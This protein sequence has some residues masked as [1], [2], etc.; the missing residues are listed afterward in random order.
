MTT[1]PERN[2]RFWPPET[3]VLW[4]LSS[5]L[6][7]GDG[8]PLDI[9]SLV[10]DT[11]AVAVA[12]KRALRMEEK[13]L[14]EQ[15]AD[16]HAVNED[17]VWRSRKLLQDLLGS[18]SRWKV[19]PNP[20][21]DCISGLVHASDTISGL[22]GS[23]LKDLA[24]A[25]M[26]RHVGV[27]AAPRATGVGP[28]R[29]SPCR[30]GLCVCGSASYPRAAAE[31]LSKFL[32]RQSVEDLTHLVLHWQSTHWKHDDPDMQNW[33]MANPSIA[34]DDEQQN[35]LVAMGFRKEDEDLWAQ[36]AWC[37]LRPFRATL[38]EVTPSL[39]QNASA[40]GIIVQEVLDA[41]GLPKLY[42][43]YTWFGDRMHPGMCYSLAAYRFSDREAP[44]GQ[45]HGQAY[46]A[47]PPLEELPDF[48]SANAHASKKIQQANP[49]ARRQALAEAVDRLIQGSAHQ[50]RAGQIPEDH[51]GD[52]GQNTEQDVDEE[53]SD[54]GLPS[55]GMVIEELYEAAV[56]FP[57][58]PAPGSSASTATRP[59][60][61]TDSSSS[62]SSSASSASTSSDEENDYPKLREVGLRK[63]RNKE[64][65]KWGP[66]R[67]TW[68]RPVDRS[69]IA[70]KPSWQATCPY[71]GDAGP[72]GT[73]RT[74]C[75]RTRKLDTSDIEADISLQ[76]ITTLKH[77]L[78]KSQSIDTKAQHQKAA[79]HVEGS[80]KR[81]ATAPATDL[82]SVDLS[83][84]PAPKHAKKL[85]PHR[86][87]TRDT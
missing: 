33:L 9:S 21:G 12:D 25:W 16:Y 27:R 77:W 42:T 45:I 55:V 19:V 63:V 41:D 13:A 34:A 48:W 78:L 7:P 57:A 76:V 70:G 38:L 50:D 6:P 29:Y 44:V 86:A 36:V 5:L 61:E 87:Q 40:G 75:T 67:F 31:R 22:Q 15:L 43:M 28:V 1:P 56:D 83:T 53:V 65:W 71:H 72:D 80:R 73:L 37:L 81:K 84:L 2:A 68:R 47:V 62:S 30:L 39:K 69:G 64:S 4:L 11:S 51:E 8:K 66:F 82:G 23:S 18:S 3:I 52:E 74:A 60:A 58:D 54:D 14:A 32:K 49:K 20:V 24:S 35:A 26:N 17:D 10:R 79:D 46:L 59:S 85:T